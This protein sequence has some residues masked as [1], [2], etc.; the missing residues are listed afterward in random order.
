[1]LI[2]ININYKSYYI[3][4]NIHGN[5]EEMEDSIRRQSERFCLF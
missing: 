1:M 5:Y 3:N 4:I 2:L